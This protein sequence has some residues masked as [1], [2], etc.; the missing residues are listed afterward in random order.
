M[1][2]MFRK[3]RIEGKN[4]IPKATEKYYVS[5]YLIYSFLCM[6]KI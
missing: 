3:L 1:E 5:K 6:G 4:L 2:E